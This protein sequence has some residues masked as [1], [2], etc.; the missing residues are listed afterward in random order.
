[1]DVNSVLQYLDSPR[2]KREIEVTTLD[3]RRWDFNV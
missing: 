2:I 3:K 1:M